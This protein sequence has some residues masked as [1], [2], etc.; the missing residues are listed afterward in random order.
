LLWNRSV[1]HLDPRPRQRDSLAD[2]NPPDEKSSEISRVGDDIAPSADFLA[3][4][5]K[6]RLA[7]EASQAVPKASPVGAVW[8]Q[9]TNGKVVRFT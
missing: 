3:G 6:K 2:A 8:Q 7:G 4:L 1:N 9:L 5:V